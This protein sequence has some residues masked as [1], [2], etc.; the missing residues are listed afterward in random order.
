MSKIL[1]IDLGTTNS[2]MAIVEGGQPKII[3][4]KEGMR[5]TPSVVAI[6]KNGERLVGVLAKRQSVTNA[7][8]T[9]FSIKRLIGRKYTDPEVQRDK[10]WLPY[11][12]RE[13]ASGGVE[14][15]MGDRWYRPEEISAMI[16]QKLKTDAEEKLGEKIEEAII[17]VPAYFDD[18]QRQATK[19]AGEIAGFKVRRI[20][21]EPTAAALAYGLNKK[22]NERIVVYDFGGGTFDI[23]ILQVSEDTVEVISTGGDTHLGGDDFDQRII[24]YFVEE[25][26]KQEGIDLSKDLLAVQRLK[27][28]AERAKHELSTVLETDVNL[29]FITSDASGPKHFEMKLTRAKLE[30][31]VKDY[32]DRSIELVKQTLAEKN[33][34][35]SDI[36]EVILVGG[37]TRMPAIQEAVKKFFGKEPHKGINP[38]EVVAMGAAVEGGILQG[39]VRDVL[40]LDVTPLSLGIETLGGVF[41]KI[42]EKNTTVPVSKSQIFSTA[43][44]NQTSVEIHVL[45]GEREMAADNKTL[46]RF[47]L[48]G[49]PPAPRGVPQIEVTFDIDA[50]GI[51][52]VTAKDKATGKE[53]SV[54][55]EASTGLTKEEIERM[56]KEAEEHLAED[57]RKREL[58]EVKNQAENTIYVAEKTLREAGEKI[59]PEDRKEVEDKINDLKQII[60]GEDLENIKKRLEDLSL[61]ISKI[62]AK[63]YQGGQQNNNPS[64][65]DN[66]PSDDKPEDA[67]FKE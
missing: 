58:A 55:I 1:G 42:I 18:S 17:T 48:D 23:S 51:L 37:Q 31:L 34:K 15:K 49:I 4:N 28:A 39:E 32:I 43:A 63:M 2:A 53:Q 56:K 16:L 36:D 10:K 57:K 41:T 3:E 35:T 64:N 20:L 13:S 54:R 8:N 38:D 30:E 29:P 62:G 27:E 14:V 45:Q 61:A 66:P 40:L 19:N 33:L 44:D 5:T 52:K 60:S 22:T 24:N 47:I 9:V 12:I 50:N 11:E 59:T 6:A 67:E 25:F 7:A 26:R 65:S 21:N 46:A